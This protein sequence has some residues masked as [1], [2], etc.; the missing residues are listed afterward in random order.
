MSFEKFTIDRM[1]S[2]SAQVQIR[3]KRLTL[4]IV[5]PNR[6]AKNEGDKLSALIFENL[7]PGTTKRQVHIVLKKSLPL[8]TPLMCQLVFEVYVKD[9]LLA[10]LAS[11]PVSQALYEALITEGN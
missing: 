11:Q 2:G 5:P 1:L 3:E 9:R 4:T 6:F 8:G 7:P 10:E